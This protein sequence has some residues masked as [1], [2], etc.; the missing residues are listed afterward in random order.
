MVMADRFF[1]HIQLCGGL[2]CGRGLC[3]G[4]DFTRF[5]VATYWRASFLWGCP[6]SFFV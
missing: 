1:L 2:G 4:S 3:L 5:G 6:L